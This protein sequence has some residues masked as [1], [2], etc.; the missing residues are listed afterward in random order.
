MD[1]GKL[2]SNLDN[3]FRF[4]AGQQDRVADV[5]ARK[6]INARIQNIR[7]QLISTTD[8]EEKE[9]LQDKL[10][11]L[12][13]QRQEIENRRYASQANFY[14]ALGNLATSAW[15]KGKTHDK[16]SAYL[17]EQ[18]AQHNVEAG[19]YQK[20]QQANMQIANR[21]TR[22][23]AEKTAA[24]EGAFKAQQAA[25]HLSAD[26]GSGAAALAAAKAAT[27]VSPDYARYE[28]RSDERRDVALDNAQSKFTSKQFGI[29][30][31]KAAASE[32][33]Q[34]QQNDRY[35]NQVQ[36]LSAGNN[37]YVMYNQEEM[38]TAQPAPEPQPETPVQ[39][40]TPEQPVTEQQPETPEQPKADN[41][42]I[43]LAWYVR[44]EAGGNTVDSIVSNV[45]QTLQETGHTVTDNMRNRIVQLAQDKVNSFNK[46]SNTVISDLGKV[47]DGNEV[48]KKPMPPLPSEPGTYTATKM[49]QQYYK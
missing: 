2:Y 12:I 13:S 31:R 4:S 46:A 26:A 33:Y 43:D 16:S 20:A 45:V 3:L 47:D 27:D 17:E 30:E 11:S 7:E 37:P 6:D 1:W 15:D 21:D 22:Q 32:D 29:Q 19:E 40:K 35:N 9:R 8:P 41:S 10:D 42:S 38:P 49:M 39:S 25:A 28:Q 5:Q 48:N 36:A 34:S 18:A 24:S 44:N 23:E 14:N